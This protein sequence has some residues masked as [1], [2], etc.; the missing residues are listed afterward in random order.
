[1]GERAVAA[2]PWD[3]V[4][5]VGL[6][7]LLRLL[8]Y[9]PGPQSEGVLA[10]T[11]MVQGLVDARRGPVAL[12]WASHYATRRREQW[13]IALALLA[14]R[15]RFLARGLRI[16]FPDAA[17]FLQQCVVDGAE[18]LESA[19]RAGG[20]IL[21]GFHVGPPVAIQLLALHGYPVMRGGWGMR[22]AAPRPPRGWR[23]TPGPDR[24]IL[25][26][27][28][29]TRVRGLYRLRQCLREGQLVG[30]TADGT[31]GQVAFRVLMPGRSVAIRAGWFGLRRATGAA[32]L[33]VLTHR[34]G[35]R[36][37]VRICPPLPAP[38]RSAG[39]DAATCREVLAPLLADY[40]RRFPEQCVSFAFS[41]DPAT[42]A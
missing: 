8:R 1:V 7:P 25:W 42:G 19:R 5:V 31:D 24:P 22:F 39:E 4:Q 10:G 20:V 41:A 35:V 21:L 17:A 9:L 12:E 26:G 36:S 11:G 2:S 3:T 14:N 37:V 33:P 6:P 28:F 34:E 23:D 30:I 38:V 13:A 16:S 29:A 40:A 18:H 15:G 32:T 27:D